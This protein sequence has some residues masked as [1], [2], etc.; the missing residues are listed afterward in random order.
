[1]A[2]CSN[3]GTKYEDGVKFCPNCGTAAPESGPAKQAAPSGQSDGVKNAVNA[4][5][6]TPDTTA[7]FDATDI[8]ENKGI[9][10]LCYFGLLLLIPLLT[11]PESKFVRFHSNQGLIFMLLGIA[12]SI[13][14]PIPVLGWVIGVVGSIFMLIC[15]ILGIVNCVNGKAKELPLIGK[16]RL[17]K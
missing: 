7:D 14:A 16:I 4:F 8:A 2:F 10:I 15:F 11:R 9:S 12:V 3:C 6:N 13:L 1:M 17:I 5:T